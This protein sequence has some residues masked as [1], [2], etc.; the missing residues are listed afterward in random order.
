MVWWH[1]WLNGHEFEQTP[2]DDEEQGSLVCCSPWGHKQLDT[3]ER[4]KNTREWCKTERTGCFKAKGRKLQCKGKSMNISIWL[5]GK[6]CVWGWG[7]G[8]GGRIRSQILKALSIV[9]SSLEFALKAA[10]THWKILNR[11]ITWLIKANSKDM[12]D[13]V[14]KAS[15]GLSHLILR[16]V[17]WGRCY[18]YAIFQWRPWLWNI[19]SSRTGY[20][21][22]Y[23]W[24]PRF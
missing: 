9:L 17:W 12:P 16:T 20:S 10:V 21:S 11:R 15:H 24:I 22:D 2:Q 3:T 18:S 13:N 1:H 23:R 7:A 14:I 8:R 4:M 6:E 19:S 5:E